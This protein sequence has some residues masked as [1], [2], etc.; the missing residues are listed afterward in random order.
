MPSAPVTPCGLC[1]N[2]LTKHSMR[3]WVG[4]AMR[5]LVCRECFVQLVRENPGTGKRQRK[6]VNEP[7]TGEQLE[8]PF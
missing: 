2:L 1:G 7:L 5:L 6:L 3:T 8:L 4:G